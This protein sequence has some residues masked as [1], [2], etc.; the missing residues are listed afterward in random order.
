VEW[1]AVKVSATPIT[2]LLQNTEDTAYT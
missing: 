1:T 2:I